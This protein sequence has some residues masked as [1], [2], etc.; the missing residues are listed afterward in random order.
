M[1]AICEANSLV[2]Y[3]T[4]G[5]TPGEPG[6]LNGSIQHSARTHLAL[7]TKAKISR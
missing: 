4:F 5:L 3:T 7:K 1:T 2:G 6:G